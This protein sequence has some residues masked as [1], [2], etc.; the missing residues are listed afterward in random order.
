[1]PASQPASHH[2][3]LENPAWSA[4]RFDK[5][6]KKYFREGV[7]VKGC[8]CGARRTGKA[9]RFW[10]AAETLEAFQELQILPD[11]VRSHCDA[12]KAGRLHSQAACP[13]KGNNREREGTPGE[14]KK[15][16]K[17]R[18]LVLLAAVIGRAMIM[19]RHRSDERAAKAHRKRKR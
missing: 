11:D 1:M 3:A 10:M 9:Y 19:G 5:Q 15:A 14:L 13:Q 17:N 18:V 6:R 2:F 12:C 7:V 16:T 8:T 4:L